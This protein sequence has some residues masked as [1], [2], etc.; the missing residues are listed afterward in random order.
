MI[1]EKQRKKILR[2]L[3]TYVEKGS[4]YKLHYTITVPKPFLH[5]TAS[6]HIFEQE[7]IEFGKGS[8]LDGIDIW[9]LIHLVLYLQSQG[10]QVNWIRVDDKFE[11]YPNLHI[12]LTLDHMLVDHILEE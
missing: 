2:Q 11:Y 9:N 5:I 8:Y 12:S 4:L 3:K 6:I 1:T 7:I 10:I